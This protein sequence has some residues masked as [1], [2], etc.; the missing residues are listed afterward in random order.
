MKRKHPLDFPGSQAAMVGQ[1]VVEVHEVYGGLFGLQLCVTSVNRD[2]PGIIACS[3]SMLDPIGPV[4]R[5][6]LRVRK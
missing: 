1:R 6:L 5:A 2:W 3:R 4:A